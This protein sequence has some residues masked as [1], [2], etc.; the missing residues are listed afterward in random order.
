V[1]LM[2]YLCWKNCDSRSMHVWSSSY[3]MKLERNLSLIAFLCVEVG[4]ARWLTPTNP[5]PRS[6]RSSTLLWELINF[7]QQVC[8][9]FMI[10]VESMDYT[11]SHPSTLLATLVPRNSR[12]CIKPLLYPSS[13]QPPY[14]PIMAFP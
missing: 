12:R 5:S 14:L 9:F 8:E 1:R 2:K 4:I 7:L 11:H 13:K 3:V 10:N 6:M